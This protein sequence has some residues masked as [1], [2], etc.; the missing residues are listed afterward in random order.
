MGISWMWTSCPCLIARVSC[1]ASSWTPQRPP[2]SSLYLVSAVRLLSGWDSMCCL[3]DPIQCGTLLCAVVFVVFVVFIVL[4]CCGIS[5]RGG[6]NCPKPLPHTFHDITRHNTTWR[7]PHNRTTPHITQDKMT[8]H[9]YTLHG[10]HPLSPSPS[11]PLSS[12]HT[13]THI[14]EKADGSP[15]VMNCST[16]TQA[17]QQTWITALQSEIDHRRKLLNLEQGYYANSFEDLRLT[18]CATSNSP[19]LQRLQSIIPDLSLLA[20]KLVRSSLDKGVASMLTTPL[21]KQL[22]LLILSVCLLTVCQFVCLSACCPLYACLLHAS[23]T[24][25]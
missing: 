13:H 20:S 14:G 12:S 7:A 10:T 22:D 21:I 18:R 25:N 19:N 2:S 23:A 15:I 3:R 1:L 4:W 5:I 17:R 24:K 16:K 11:L 6:A 9:T 8:L